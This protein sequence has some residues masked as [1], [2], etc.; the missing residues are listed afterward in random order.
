[1]IFPHQFPRRLR[2]LSL[3]ASC[4][5]GLA[6][7]AVAQDPDGCDDRLLH[8]LTDTTHA[9]P[10]PSDS[11]RAVMMAALGRV[12]PGTFLRVH[13]AGAGRVEG[14]VTAKSETA[15]TFEAGS[16]VLLVPKSGINSVWA[17]ESRS[18]HGALVGILTGGLIGGVLTV[19]VGSGEPFCGVDAGNCDPKG[20]LFAKGALVGG[21]LGALLGAAFGS[22]HHEWRL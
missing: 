7:V 5:V 4:L 15:L 13:M 18:S 2:V 11:A 16:S 12:A 9:R 3:C 20:L 14:R 10:V 19:V 22:G 21:S 8:L 6:Q 17:R 1:M